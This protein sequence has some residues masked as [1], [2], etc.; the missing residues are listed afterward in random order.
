MKAVR[1]F[2]GM[3]LLFPASGAFCQQRGKITLLVDSRELPDPKPRNAVSWQGLSP[4][5]MIRFADINRRYSKNDPPPESLITQW[6]STAWRGEKVHTQLLIWSTRALEQVSVKAGALKNKA[7]VPI[8]ASCITT[9]FIKYVMTDGLNKSG[10]GCGIPPSNESDSSLVEDAIDRSSAGKVEANTTRPVWL[11]ISVPRNTSPGIYT[12][13]LRVYNDGKA[14]PGT[15]IYRILVKDHVL[16]EPKDR[17]FHLDLWQNPYSIARVHGVKEWSVQHF[18]AMRPY[19][20]MLAAAGQKAI[21]VSM[22]YDPWRG[23]TYDI[24]GSMIKWIKRKDGTW[25]YDYSIFDR[26]VTFMQ[27]LGI[28]KVIN[29]YSMEPWN[30]TFY[31]YN[32]AYAKDTFVI[33]RPGTLEYDAHW[34]PMLTSFIKHLKEKNWF[35]KT[36]LAMD[37][38]PLEDMQQVIA[39]VRSVDK[40]IK[41]SLA[42]S[43]HTTIE[44]DIYDYSIGSSDSFDPAIMAKRLA[45]G[46]PTTYYTC[47]VE[48]YPNTFTFSPPAEAAWLGWFAANEHYNGYLR[49]A[50]N[51]WPAQPVQDSRFRTWSAGDTYLVY[52]GPMSSI[53]FER[54]IEGIQDYEKISILKDLFK[55]TRQVQKL[56]QLQQVLEAFEPAALKHRS[57]A[58]MLQEA[59]Q[60]VNAF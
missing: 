35:S 60:A 26:W 8:P 28:D 53:R 22:I 6:K 36:A 39:F 12:G 41:I 1:Y 40:S 31:Y 55:H 11:S 57:A 33:A 46:L 23:Q 42:G 15:L 54:M 13:S 56:K 44:K 50:Y 18:E 5:V 59:K 9:G 10:G 3:V 7:G 32:E 4:A 20:K 34:R 27:S 37:E 21:T 16:P 19:M 29:C 47:C 48:G 38:R 58:D 25:Q 52:P 30:F 17:T 43:Y 49:W 45:R 51:C 14:L 24:Y 2:L